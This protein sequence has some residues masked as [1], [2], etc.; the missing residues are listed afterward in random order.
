[1]QYIILH[2]FLILIIVEMIFN[3]EPY[4][5]LQLFFDNTSVM[6]ITII[7]HLNHV[8]LFFTLL[9]AAT[10]VVVLYQENYQLWTGLIGYGLCPLDSWMVSSW[11]PG[12]TK[13][14]RPK[15]CSSPAF[16]INREIYSIQKENECHWKCVFYHLC[17]TSAT[18]NR[19]NSKKKYI[20]HNT[21]DN[22]SLWEMFCR[23]NC[24]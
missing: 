11:I 4:T 24:C 9:M 5:R 18:D 21:A 6:V 2:P 17:V 15:R 20:G 13:W 8:T 1:M 10:T 23:K 22:L 7:L 14:C 19:E 12:R 3:H 16:P